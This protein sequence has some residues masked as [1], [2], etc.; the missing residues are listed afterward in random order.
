MIQRPQTSAIE[1]CEVRVVHLARATARRAVMEVELRR[2]GITVDGWNA[3]DAQDGANAARLADMPDEGPWGPMHGHAKGCLLSH[4]DA[5]AAFLDGPASHLLL[6]EDDTFLA[7]DLANW[8]SGAH[9]PANAHV[10]KL[11]RWRDDRLKILV[12]RAARSH[13]GR[14]LRRLWSRHSGSAGYMINRAGAQMVLASGVF[15]LPIDHLLF[16]PYVSK[17]SR[18][19]VIFQVVPA[20]VV[21][22]NE[23]A[24]AVAAAGGSAGHMVRQ[25]LSLQM[26][27]LAAELMVLRQLPRLLAGQA[28]LTSI[29][30]Q[31]GGKPLPDA[32]ETP[33][34]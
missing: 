4:L 3:V 18:N 26:K 2:V 15:D 14:D 12:D 30:W 31:S 13:S 7:D 8:L 28:Y 21:Q 9:W 33:K 27:R 1:H 34:G 19:L 20:A 29:S 22:G 23:P 24:P 6:L 11:E 5:L 25:S 16:N 32:Q 10:I 17:V